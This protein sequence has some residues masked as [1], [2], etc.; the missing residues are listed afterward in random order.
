[1][2]VHYMYN[3]YYIPHIYTYSTRSPTIYMDMCV[4]VLYTHSFLGL[5]ELS[6]L[7]SFLQRKT[8]NRHTNIAATKL[9]YLC[10]NSPPH[11]S[12]SS[13]QCSSCFFEHILK[14]DRLMYTMCTYVSVQQTILEHI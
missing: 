2:Y 11:A 3:M 9:C 5:I 10:E 6:H 4:C 7:Q 8:P 13:K 14:F 12:A 1:M